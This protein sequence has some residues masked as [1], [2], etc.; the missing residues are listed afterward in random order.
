LSESEQAASDEIDTSHLG[1]SI[2]EEEVDTSPVVRRARNLLSTEPGHHPPPD[3]N[4]I[5]PSSF[6]GQMFAR[7]NSGPV[8]PKDP[9]EAEE[10]AFYVK[11]REQDD[12][13]P[14]S[15]TYQARPS[16]AELR[17]S[18]RERLH[19]VVEGPIETIEIPLEKI[20][21]DDFERRSTTD[22]DDQSKLVASI[23]SSG[24]INPLT[25][26]RDEHDPDRYHLICGGHRLDALRSLKKSHARCTVRGPL[27]DR[28]IL[29]MNLGENF[30]RRTITSFQLA[31][32]I[33]L[34]VRKFLAK[35]EEVAGALGLSAVHVRS[36]LRYLSTLPPDVVGD[37]KA[38]HPA[39]THRMLA[40]L[41]REPF[42]S[43]VWQSIRSRSEL[44]ENVVPSTYVPT[45]ADTDESGWEP[46][47]RPTRAKLARLRD[48]VMR[49][50]LPA[51]PEKLREILVG[52]VD[53][54]RGAK[55]SIP[56]LLVPTLKERPRPRRLAQTR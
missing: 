27:S 55:R 39:L 32:Q 50:K 46:Y 8:I 36:L 31:E 54:T 13:P 30:A 19:P 9:T 47:K 3:P 41:V 18:V 2:T 20:L 14:A 16:I 17:K 43:R 34:I 5:D 52:L 56:H 21:D 37:W 15:D 51:D 53:W 11:L 26:R 42:P 6:L 25:V 40:R 33:E 24:L 35:P 4:I 1:D 7:A 49:A 28:D 45:E 29:L 44:A 38:G 10:I 12:L 22:P 23:A 48:I